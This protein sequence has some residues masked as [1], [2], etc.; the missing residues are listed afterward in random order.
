MKNV[1]FLIPILLLCFACEEQ[2]DLADAYGNFE[3][4]ELVIS[5]EANGKLMQFELEEGQVLKK[6]QIIGFI[7]TTQLHLKK[8][9]LLASIKT[10]S[11]KQQDAEPQVAVYEEQKKNLLREK[12][13]V[14]ALLKDKAATPKQLDDIM[15][16]IEVVDR[17]IKAAREQSQTFNQGLLGETAPIRIQIKQLEDQ[18]KK[19]YITNPVN[20]T[21]LLKLAEASEF[22]NMGK[23]LYKIAELSEMDLRIFVS[24]MQ[25]PKIKL[26]QEV[27]VFIDEDETNNK[28][29]SGVISWISD[30][31]EFTPK[32]V[33]TKEE[34]VN[35]VYAVKV[36][37]K[38]DGALK[39]GMPG[40]VRF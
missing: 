7:D 19:S 25:L 36:T 26:G 4:Q 22:V 17:Q 1:L 33:Q 40:E 2:T 21:V 20:G 38:N 16:Q 6:G 37:V 11:G 29:I 9:Q 18:I 31:A 5:A 28:Q 39:I 32:I 30:K 10:I 15:G 12:N 24:G 23:P 3:A 13:R 35:L 34:R 14:E 8:E 27:N